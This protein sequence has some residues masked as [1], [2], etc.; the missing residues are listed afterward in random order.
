M[1]SYAIMGKMSE[2]NTGLSANHSLV[3][4]AER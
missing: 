3:A 2:T 4:G 1:L